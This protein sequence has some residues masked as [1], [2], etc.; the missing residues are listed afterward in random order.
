MDTLS[1]KRGFTLVELLVVIA[2]IGILIGLLLPAIQAVREAARRASCTSNLRQVG[3]AL[4]NFHDAQRTFPAAS[5]YRTTNAKQ[6]WGYSWLTYLLPYCEMGNLW[7]SMKIR[8]NTDPTTNTMA[9]QTR[10][11]AYVCPSYSGPEYVIPAQ[12][13]T[14]ASGAIANYKTIGATTQTSL[15]LAS[16]PTPVGTA[17]YG[18]KTDHPDGTI[19]PGK[20]LRMADI[21]DGTSN[22]VIACETR[23]EVFAQWQ[24]GQYATLVG[25]PPGYTFT[26]PA[27]N[28]P[29]AVPKGFTIGQYEDNSTITPADLGTYLNYDYEDNA[30]DGTKEGTTAGKYGAS[31]WHKGIVNHLFADNDVRALKANVDVALYMFVITRAGGD[32][33]SE[34][35]NIYK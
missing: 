35:F 19:F 17:P 23:E 25:L 15:G 14:P 9:L 7:D 30:Y 24:V 21:P 8:V 5:E 3:T 29:Y 26:P 13:T 16:T 18:K 10:V 20:R 33:A 22:T 6:P 11:G 28:Q 34:F 12:G 27:Q 31:S 32:P 2:I 4:H 1:R